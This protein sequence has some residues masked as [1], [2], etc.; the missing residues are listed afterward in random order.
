MIH[1]LA[2]IQLIRGDGIPLVTCISPVDSLT[3]ALSKQTDG[4]SWLLGGLVT[5]LVR[6]SNV[7]PQPDLNLIY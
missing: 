2:Q 1:L 5:L 7:C 4:Y 6:D 3:D